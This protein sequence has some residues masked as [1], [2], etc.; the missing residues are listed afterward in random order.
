MSGG[1]ERG[2][3][4]RRIP[5][6]FVLLSALATGILLAPLLTPPPILLWISAILFL[7]AAI[8]LIRRAPVGIGLALLAAPILLHGAASVRLAASPAAN[9][10][11]AL[12]GSPSLWVYGRIISDIEIR[13]AR[14]G[15]S[16]TATLAAEACGEEHDFQP[17]S[18]RLRITASNSTPPI[19]GN[20]I[21]IRGRIERPEG[22]TNP[23]GFDYRAYL[24]RRGIYA[25]LLARHSA[26]VR[27]ADKP[28]E[29]TARRWIADLQ[30][31]IGRI[32]AAHLPP[33]DAVLLS[34]LLLG[35]HGGLPAPLQDAVARTGTIHLLTA[36]GLH[37]GALTAV[38]FVLFS[39]LPISRRIVCLSCLPFVW[40]FALAAGA[41]PAVIRATL[42]ATV[43]LLA[44]LLRRVP[45]SLTSW[46]F[47]AFVVLL[48]DPLSLY[49]A[50]FLLS[51]GV[52]F[53]LILYLGPLERWTLPFEPGMRL[54]D[55]VARGALLG[56]L[57]SVVAAIAS[58]PL[59]A[60]YFNLL[61]PMTPAANLLAAPLAEILLIA[62]LGT[63]ALTAA[64]PTIASPLMLPLW[65]LLHAGLAALRWIILSFA[66]IPF[67]AVSVASP[68]AG[69]IIGYYVLLVGIAPLVRRRLL[70]HT[71]LSTA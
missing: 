44:P 47:A 35:D 48:A 18:G 70:R 36:A 61:S 64:L 57:L 29:D 41:G 65:W 42:M 62:G 67:S 34:G 51:F 56:L 32:I 55:R 63:T 7:I 20:E 26:D 25:T 5:R 58:G 31:G 24:A 12:S 38:L 19:P 10:I 60:Y 53:I 17:V 43:V 6:I 71:F 9:D 69:L 49:D 22:Q 68:P 3:L 33:D 2:F 1:D 21:F 13:P 27:I 40:I 28:H 8:L 14:Q 39:Q 52:V 4:S 15:I 45:D 30:S 23:D 50:G 16:W 59:N 54:T 46:A 11:S 37:V 66:A